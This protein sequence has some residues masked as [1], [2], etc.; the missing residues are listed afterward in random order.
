MLFLLY[1]QLFT[2]F[3]GVMLEKILSFTSF[4]WGLV[5]YLIIFNGSDTIFKKIAGNRKLYSM[6]LVI[7]LFCLRFVNCGFYILLANGYDK[8]SFIQSDWFAL[9][10]T[11]MVGSINGFCTTAFFVLGPEKVKGPD[12]E[13]VGFLS[14]L[15]LLSGIFLGSLLAIPFSKLN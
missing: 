5:I 9:L 7:F 12:K 1:T 6:K 4:S 14:V 2:F 13:K 10:N 8:F 15:G 3:P 11:F